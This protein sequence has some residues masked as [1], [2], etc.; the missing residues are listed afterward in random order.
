MTYNNNT[1]VNNNNIQK[2]YYVCVKERT[3]AV[4]PVPCRL[5]AWPGSLPTQAETDTSDK[6]RVPDTG[7]CVKC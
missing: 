6:A 7:A 3:A 5:V 4:G 1:K 2:Q